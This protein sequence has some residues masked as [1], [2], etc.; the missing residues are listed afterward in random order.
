[1]LMD[2][3]MPVMDGIAATKAIKRE[4][5]HT[6]VLIL[7]AVDESGGLSDSLEAGATLASSRPG[8]P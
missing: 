7:T 8:V 1:V 4:S 2:L 3:R 5:P 6:L